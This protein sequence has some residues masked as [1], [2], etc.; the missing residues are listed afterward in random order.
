MRVRRRLEDT[1]L[2]NVAVLV[3]PFT[4]FLLT[5]TV[6]ASGVLAA[7]VCGLIMSQAGPRTGRAGTRR[8]TEAFW[9]LATFLLNGSLFVLI[10]IELHSQPSAV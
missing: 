1:L 10:G 6:H 3:I 7:V 9:S 5:E 8:Q 4:A 2:D